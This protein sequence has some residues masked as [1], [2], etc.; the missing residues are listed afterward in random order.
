MGCEKVCAQW[1]KNFVCSR[2]DAYQA[3]YIL[4]SVIVICAVSEIV[5]EANKKPSELNRKGESNS[6]VNPQN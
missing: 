6:S 1:P 4:D 3:T 5:A 2:A